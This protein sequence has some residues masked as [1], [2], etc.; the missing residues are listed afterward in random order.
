MNAKNILAFVAVA[1]TGA[2]GIGSP[3]LGAA[4][5][6]TDV[7]IK[8]DEGDYLGKVTSPEKY[9]LKDR[10]VTV[11]KQVGSQ[12]DRGED[13]KIGTDLTDNQGKWSAGNTGYKKGRFYAY[14]KRASLVARVAYD[15]CDNAR[16]DVI[17]R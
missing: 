14:V 3:A 16:S 4:T 5:A 7:T 1:L 15:A 6:P 13:R 12:P 10:Q 17:S 11:Y 2:L 9:C 8:G